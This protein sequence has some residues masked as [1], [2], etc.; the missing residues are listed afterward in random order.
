M[1]HKQSKQSDLE[2]EFI[3][4]WRLLGTRTVPEPIAQHR[5]CG[6]R[7]R[8]DWCWPISMTACELQG[9][10]W[11]RGRHTRGAGYANDC[12]KMIIGQCL[13]WLVFWLTS[14]MLRNDP[15]T[16]ISIIADAA[17]KRQYIQSG[18]EIDLNGLD[19]RKR[20]G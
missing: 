5:F 10:T 9:G 18:K 20:P 8:W 13:G 12:E 2:A 4:Y 17:I 14:D 15:Q 11:T 16:W 7:Y 19:Q 6:R 1:R 3:H